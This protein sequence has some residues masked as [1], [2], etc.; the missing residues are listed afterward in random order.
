MVAFFAFDIARKEGGW[1][2]RLR[3]GGLQTQGVRDE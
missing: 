1:G 3:G 2:W